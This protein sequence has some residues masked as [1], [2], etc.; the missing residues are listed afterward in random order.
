MRV[1]TPVFLMFI[2]SFSYGTVCTCN[3]STGITHSIQWGNSLALGTNV[4]NSMMIKENQ[5]RMEV[6]SIVDLNTEKLRDCQHSRFAESDLG[7]C[8]EDSIGMR[9]ESEVLFGME[10]LRMYKH[11]ESYGFN[12]KQVTRARKYVLSRHNMVGEAGVVEYFDDQDRLLGRTY[13]AGLTFMF[14]LYCE[15]EQSL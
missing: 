12:L 15:N 11:P 4:F 5:G 2:S 7:S 14:R 9:N 10:Y 13:N 8:I 1:L 6:L 3:L